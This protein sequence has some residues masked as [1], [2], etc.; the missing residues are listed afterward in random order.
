LEIAHTLPTKKTPQKESMYNYF[1]SRKQKGKKTFLNNKD[2][3]DILKKFPYNL[4]IKNEFAQ[5]EFN[6]EILFDNEIRITLDQII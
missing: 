2:G 4:I 6:R 5:L 3:K 1:Y